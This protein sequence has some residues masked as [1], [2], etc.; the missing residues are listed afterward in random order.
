MKRA[1]LNLGL[2]I[3]LLDLVTEPYL[4]FP[5]LFVIPVGVCAWFNGRGLAYALSILLPAGRFFVAVFAETLIP[6]P[7]AFANAL[8]RF[9]VLLLLAYFVSRSAAQTRKLQR[10]VTLLQL[11]WSLATVRRLR[12][13]TQRFRGQPRHLPSVR[14]E[15]LSRAGGRILAGSPS[16]GDLAGR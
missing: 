13:G 16:R 8:T 6:P 5:I 12:H 11:G 7:Y 1:A 3:L 15:A 10:E 9:A 2:A 14:R 4:L